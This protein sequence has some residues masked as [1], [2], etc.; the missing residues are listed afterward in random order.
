MKQIRCPRIVEFLQSI[1]M[2]W[3][4]IEIVTDS[5]PFCCLQLHSEREPRMK[6]LG[7]DDKVRAEPGSR[8][9]SV[10][11]CRSA[12]TKGHSIV[13]FVAHPAA[14]LKMSKDAR[15]HTRDQSSHPSSFHHQNAICFNKATHVPVWINQLV[16]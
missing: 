9:P 7:E 16:N 1:A 12:Q 6:C 15:A 4:V 8:P 13:H 5:D 10:S 14:R 2:N 11:R 3:H